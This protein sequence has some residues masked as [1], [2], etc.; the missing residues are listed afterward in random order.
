MEAK[1]VVVGGKANKTAVAL[2]LPTIIGRSREAGLTIAHPMISRQHCELSEKDGL[3]ILRDLGSTNGTILDGRRVDVAPL[4]PNA[5]FS[6]GPLTFRADYVY[7]GDLD[8]APSPK[9]FAAEQ[10]ETDGAAEEEELDFLAVE[11]TEEPPAEEPEEAG[12]YEESIDDEDLAFDDFIEDEL[13]PEAAGAENGPAVVPLPQ[14]SEAVEAEPSETADSPESLADDELS[15]EAD[16]EAA[17]E[18]EDLEFVEPDAAAPPT[19]SAGAEDDIRQA[20]PI[21][22]GE[23]GDDSPGSTPLSPKP[24]KRRN[25]WNRK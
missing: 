16:A 9:F 1:L 24:S 18:F 10:E 11:E 2:K 4:L 19:D 22:S 13:A 15:A 5:Q 25:C 3:L 6:I 12:E 20:S 21:D 7:D 8:S 17:E 14:P 23:A